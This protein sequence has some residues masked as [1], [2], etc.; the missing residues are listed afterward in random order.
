MFHVGDKVR[1]LSRS[2]YI[3]TNRRMD[4]LCDKSPWQCDLGI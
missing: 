2:P 1:A 3:I 4:W